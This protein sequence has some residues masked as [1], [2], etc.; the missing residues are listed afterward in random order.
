[1]PT[2]RNILTT[3]AAIAG[4]T[5][6]GRWPMAHAQTAHETHAATQPENSTVGSSGR[7]SPGTHHTPVISPNCGTLP[8]RIVDGVK[9][10]HL[11]AEEVDHEFAPGLRAKCWGYNGQTPGPTIEA[12]E[13]DRLR[14]FVTNKLPEP[15]TIHWHGLLLPAGMDGV[16]GLNQKPIPPGETFRYEFTLRQHGTHMYHPHYDEMTQMGMGMMGMFI[17]HPRHPV[18]PRI[19]R[20]FALI[21][22][23]WFIKPGTSRPDPTAMNDFNLLTFNHKVFPATAPLVARTGDRVRMRIGNLS[24]MD[25]HPIH[26]H[27]YQFK[28]TQTDGG[29]IPETAQWPEVTVLVPTG[30]TRTIEF[31]ADA[32]GDWAMHCHMLHH[33]MT[34]MGHGLPNLIGANVSS[35]DDKITPLLPEF[36]TMGNT[37]MG[38][39]GEMNM[40]V[41]RN[42]LPMRGGDG[43]FGYIDMGGMFTIL[44]VRDGL[45]TYDDP[46]WYAHPAGTV[47]GP[48]T[49]EELASMNIMKTTP[50]T[51]SPAQHESHQH[52]H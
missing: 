40:P 11:I 50:M 1:M 9:I 19:D 4:G 6:L 36:M 7:E 14:I 49:A 45:T 28:I 37:G 15:T 22:S 39:M 20:D 29:M 5:L 8:F 32:P 25:H 2:R 23:E 17:I 43:P 33:V 41:P 48:A 3:S 16:S 51:P 13:G 26:I 52:H 21:L 18:G 47:A 44:K 27:G 31:I 24:A 12:V 34:Q 30:S 10:M 35:I 46:G 38:G 42:S